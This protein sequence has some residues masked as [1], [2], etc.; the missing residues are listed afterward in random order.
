MA[1]A[2]RGE[3]EQVGVS[4]EECGTTSPERVQGRALANDSSREGLVPERELFSE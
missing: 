2:R 4:G 1:P 3:R